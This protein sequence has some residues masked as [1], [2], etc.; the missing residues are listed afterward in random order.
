MS[1]E[2][3]R[4][5][6]RIKSVS[7]ALKVTSAM[8]LVSAVKLKKWKNRMLANKEYAELVEKT[9]SD[10]FS[11]VPS[12]NNPFIFPKENANKDLYIIVSST[13][14]LCG[15]YNSNIFALADVSIKENDD[16]I[17]L[18]NKGAVHFDGSNFNKINDYK[19]YG[20]IQDNGVIKSITDFAV[21]KFLDGTYK[22]VHIIHSTYKNSIVFLAKDFVLLPMANIKE[23][24][25]FAYPPIFEPNIKLVAE[26][27]LPIYLKSA[28]F[29]KFLESEVCEQAARNNAMNNATDNANEILNQLQ[30]EFNKAR[31]ASITQ[32]IIE[33]SAASKNM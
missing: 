4:I 14:G 1:Q 11:Y 26:K 31:Q 22:S 7:G 8:K 2:I 6:S 13:L 27:L 20:G 18:G 10:V 3:T 32:E 21:N 23:E 17:I 15:S 25:N 24:D 30:I 16:A 12:K 28:V 29:S 9:T 5:K 19:D 33:I